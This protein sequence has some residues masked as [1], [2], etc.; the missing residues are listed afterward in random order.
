MIESNVKRDLE[1]KI[2]LYINGKLSADEVDDLWSELIQD[3]YYL[4][5]TKTFANLKDLI[6]AKRIQTEDRKPSRLRLVAGYASAAA[7]I[8]FISFVG[9]MNISNDQGLDINAI[10]NIPLDT[11]RSAEGVI[12]EEMTDA[13]IQ[14]AIELANR[15]EVETAISILNEELEI[16]NSD[17]R[18][19]KIGLSLGAIQYN[20]GDYL[21]SIGSFE[22]TVSQPDIEILTLEKGYFYLGNAYFQVDL[23]EKARDAFRNAYDLN[24]QYRRV[25]KSYLDVISLTD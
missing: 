7:V 4:D 24:G 16:T 13:R 21:S 9:I 8:I 10:G 3:D 20:N 19:A 15:G 5:Y 14:E 22:L 2:D 1:R 11:Y 6:E 18:I 12:N 23:N 25:A 17:S